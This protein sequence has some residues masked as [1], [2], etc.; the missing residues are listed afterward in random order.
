MRVVCQNKKCKHAELVHSGHYC[1]YPS[2]FKCSKCGSRVQPDKKG[3]E[4]V[5]RH[6]QYINLSEGVRTGRITEEE[7]RKA[8]K[9]K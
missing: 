3:K 2:R 4:Q 1:R 8:L 5:K 9:I 7:M 6:W